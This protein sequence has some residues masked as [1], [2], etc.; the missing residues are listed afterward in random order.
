MSLSPC[1]CIGSQLTGAV[2]CGLPGE[3]RKEKERKQKLTLYELGILQY[4]C[5]KMV[6]QTTNLVKL[7]GAVSCGLPGEPRKE[8]EQ[9]LKWPMSR[10]T[11]ELPS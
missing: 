8:K 9:K 6:L 3:P 2:S 1:L 4:D 5:Y 11:R 10:K 7:T